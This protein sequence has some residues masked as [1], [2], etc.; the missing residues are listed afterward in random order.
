MPLCMF[1]VLPMWPCTASAMAANITSAGNTTW[2][3]KT[4]HE[5]Y[6][7]LPPKNLF[8]ELV[9]KSLLGGEKLI[10]STFLDNQEGDTPGDIFSSLVDIATDPGII[11]GLAGMYDPLLGVACEAFLMSVDLLLG[12]GQKDKSPWLS[13]MRKLRDEIMSDVKVMLKSTDHLL[14]ID[15]ISSDMNG[16]YNTIKLNLRL[17][18][19]DREA[20]V[21]IMEN[22]LTKLRSLTV[23]VFHPACYG[24][25]TNQ[26]ECRQWRQ[27][28]SIVVELAF[29]HLHALTIIDIMYHRRKLG[30]NERVEIMKQELASESV[31]IARYPA[32]L[33]ASLSAFE[34]YQEG[35]IAGWIWTSSGHE[36]SEQH[37]ARISAGYNC[38]SKEDV[39]T[40]CM[41]Q[42]LKREQA[43]RRKKC[44]P[45]LKKP[46]KK[47]HC[48]W[49]RRRRCHIERICWSCTTML[50]AGCRDRQ[51]WDSPA[52]GGGP[53]E[54]YAEHKRIMK[55]CRTAY[56]EHRVKKPCQDMRQRIDFIERI[57]AS[58]AS[59]LPLPPPEPNRQE[60][61]SGS[62]G[63]LTLPLCQ[64]RR[65]RSRRRRRRRR[66]CVA[67]DML[68]TEKNTGLVA[69][70]DL[71]PG[72]SVRGVA[73]RGFSQAAVWCDV[74][75][76]VHNGHGR[77]QGNFTAS[78]FLV[79]SE[80][81]IVPHGDNAQPRQ[82][83]LC[84]LVTDCPAV[85]AEDQRLFTPYSSDF[86]N[87]SL[88]WSEYIR[89]HAAILRVVART[90][91]FWFSPLNYGM[92][93]SNA[94][95]N[96]WI[97]TLPPLCEGL[98]D[99][100]INGACNDFEQEA[101]QLVHQH[102]KLEFRLIVLDKYPFLGTPY[103]GISK[104]VVQPWMWSAW[105]TGV[106]AVL[107]GLLVLPCVLLCC[108]KCRRPTKTRDCADVAP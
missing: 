46:C 99:C 66:A 36:L 34:H 89:L 43:W 15:G 107:C 23:D 2:W 8:S 11:G 94:S 55:K 50:G 19:S 106:V 92:N 67:C 20:Y 95:D 40:W 102:L 69:V 79:D 49:S 39:L 65:R 81:A 100:T 57:V 73:G 47:V 35:T 63:D 75:A 21:D 108:R 104:D 86:C 87:R 71:M 72:H 88:Q 12:G 68:V 38:G 54:S 84:D 37:H 45:G 22:E 42:G 9:D 13:D 6:A 82:G 56:L 27:S 17:P 3:C 74:K 64:G 76:S 85:Y 60:D 90:G 29:A 51:Y 59:S 70:K 31:G 103:L 1:Y 98:L 52:S 32:L 5:H 93:S 44:E 62:L 105:V 33:R 28:G 78:H 24:V 4:M 10:H 83:A 80:G 91:T 48:G 61:T 97:E 7:S 14:R 101:S 77:L 30:Q 96:R 18:C 26:E 16:I 41:Q 25:R 53:C 58:A